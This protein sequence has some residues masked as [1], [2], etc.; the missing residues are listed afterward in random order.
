MFLGVNL[1][2]REGNSQTVDYKITNYGWK[3]SSSSLYFLFIIFLILF[4]Q[5]GII[6]L[7]QDFLEGEAE[8]VSGSLFF[9][10]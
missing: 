2:S 1:L 7:C 5:L 6:L 8:M 3:L 10:L 4:L 9:I